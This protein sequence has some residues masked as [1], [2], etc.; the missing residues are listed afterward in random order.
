[1]RREREMLDLILNTAREDPRVRAVI[2]NGS[3]VNPHAPK[4][5]FQDYDIQYIVTDIE[6]FRADPDWIRVFGE[7]MIL[8]LPDDM[9]DPP[10][11]PGD[12]YAYLMQF[13]DGNRIDLGLFPLSRL[14]ELREDS[15]SLTLL[16][17]DG[18]LPK[19]PPPDLSG[20]KTKPPTAKQFHDCTNEFWWCA[21]YVAK[22]LWRNEIIYARQ[23]FDPFLREQLDKML[24]WY[25]GVSSDF[26]QD[27]GKMG[28]Y[29][30]KCLDPE[31]WDY[32][33]KTYTDADYE[34]TWQALFT[35][36]DLF[37]RLAIPVAEHFGYAYP[38]SDD[39]RVSAHLQHVHDLPRDAQEMYT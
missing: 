28:K 38:Y 31:L 16:D 34:H 27:S 33:L 19:F 9:T 25:I 21:P 22:G 30:E 5:I 10:P 15:L 29:L 13:M 12:H 23:M 26:Q 36:G 4:D 1:M 2:M 37:R 7:L 20:Y 32:L 18:I 11:D 35:M 8:Q 3:R 14:G 39:S 24:Q 17:K 6:S